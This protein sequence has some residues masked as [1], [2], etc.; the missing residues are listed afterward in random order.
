MRSQLL[1]AHST[2]EV[3]NGELHETAGLTAEPE[4]EPDYTYAGSATGWSRMSKESY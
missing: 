4:L 2:S 3:A 1:Q